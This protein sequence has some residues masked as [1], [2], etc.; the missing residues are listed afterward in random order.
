MLPTPQVAW[1]GAPPPL[2][3][4]EFAG[5][6][7]GDAELRRGLEALYDLF[8][9]APTL[10]SLIEPIGGD[11]ID[12]TR[13][14]RIE[15][16]IIDLVQRMRDAEPGR[17]EGALAARGM[18]DAAAILS[19]RWVLQTTNVPFLG[20]GRQDDALMKYIAARFDIAKP[21]LATAMLA[22]LRSLAAP[23]GTVAAVSPQN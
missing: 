5:L 17:T 16:S 3:K 4:V 1:V 13:V 21:D 18:A 14:A 7:N 6:A 9:Q 10:G 15:D 12:P 22:R 11:L 2:P 23:G 20:R 8:A 19:L